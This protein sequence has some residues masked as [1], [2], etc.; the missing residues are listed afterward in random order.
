MKDPGWK[1]EFTPDGCSARG[2]V[3]IRLMQEA[4]GILEGDKI[5]GLP[6]WAYSERWDIEAKVDEDDL[7]AFKKLDWDHQ[8]LMLQAVLTDR[9][10]L[11]VHRENHL[12]PSYILVVGKKG[13]RIRESSPE[14]VP[15]TSVKRSGSR[16]SLRRGRLTV[17]RMTMTEFAKLLSVQVRRH[18]VDKTGLKS[19]YDLTLEWTPD[20]LAAPVPNSSNGTLNL[21]DSSVPSIFTAI[22]DQLGLRLK[23][24]KEPVETLVIDQLERPTEN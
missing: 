23:S 5:V 12:Q 24:G 8:K 18:V 1:L 11:I 9:F 7:A 6:T 16:V 22:K 21:S 17:E 19:H 13:P 2:I 10:K 15:P 4:F 14:V 20:N 3:M